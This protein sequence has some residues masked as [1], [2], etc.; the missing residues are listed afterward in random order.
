MEEYEI[1]NKVD[2]WLGEYLEHQSQPETSSSRQVLRWEPPLSG[3]FKINVDVACLEEEGTG[4]GVLVRDHNSN[5]YCA[6]IQ[7]K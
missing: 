6:S 4:F 1:M 2:R 5:F 3:N 7:C